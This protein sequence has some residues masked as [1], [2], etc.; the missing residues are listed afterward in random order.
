MKNILLHILLPLISRFKAFIVEIS[1]LLTK[2][3]PLNQES[4]EL[5]R[6]LNEKGYVVYRNTK[7]VQIANDI[8]KHYYS[9]GKEIFKF[10]NKFI[11]KKLTTSAEQIGNYSCKVSFSDPLI[12]NVM[13]DSIIWD[14]LNGYIGKSYHRESPLIEQH[15]FRNSAEATRDI[16]P[17]AVSFHTD[18]YRQI[19]IM[20]L[21]TDITQDDTCTEYAVGSHLRNVFIE[22]V[23]IGY[24]K[25]N[26]LIRKRGYKIEKITGK[27]GDIVIMDTTGIHRAS[28]AE[29]SIRKMLVG[30]V[31]CNY[32]FLGYSENVSKNWFKFQDKSISSLGVRGL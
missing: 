31:N 7:F 8:N 29:G 27:M 26:K 4:Q 6:I 18:Y 22:G 11:L 24:P 14:A 32:P 21:L 28:V 10:G 16:V 5:L 17:Y 3:K 2:K 25:T 20:L 9:D 13:C 12:R 1:I 30:V 19:N 15:Q 23:N